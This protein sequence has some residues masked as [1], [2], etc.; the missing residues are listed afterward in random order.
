MTADPRPTGQDG[1]DENRRDRLSELEKDFLFA[2]LLRLPSLFV[3]A[4]E[5]VTPRQ[6]GFG[7]KDSHYACLWQAALNVAQRHGGTMP[8]HPAAARR[9]LD[10]EVR[11][12][13]DND[14]ESFLSPTRDGLLGGGRH[15]AGIIAFIYVLL[16][17]ELCEKTGRDYFRRFLEER[18]VYDDM[19][20]YVASWGHDV[21]HSL[22]PYLQKVQQR[23]A[24]IS[25]LEA[26]ATFA[27]FPERRAFKPL[28]LF[29]TGVP[30]MDRLMNGG[31]AGGEAYTLM[32]PTK[33]GKTTLALQMAVQT[34]LQFQR[35][36]ADG[37]GPLLHVFYFSYEEPVEPRLLHRLWAHLAQIDYDVLDNGLEFTSQE[38]KDYRPYEH[39]RWGAQLSRGLPVPG[40][41]ERFAKACE[42][43]GNRNFW[44][45]DFSGAVPGQGAGGVPEALAVL[46][47][48]RD[49]GKHVGMIVIDYTGLAVQRMLVSGRFSRGFKQSDEFALIQSFPYEVVCQIA[50]PFNCACWVLHQLHGS[51][52]LK[53]PTAPMHHARA[54][55]SRNF[56]DNAAFAFE[57]GNLDPNTSCVWLHRT[58]A[59]RAAPV[60]EP[61]LVRLDGAVRTMVDASEEYAVNPHTK[62]IVRRDELS[63]VGLLGGAS[64]GMEREQALVDRFR[65]NQAR[66]SIFDGMN[67]DK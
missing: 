49:A 57:L 65:S 43:L 56:A 11:R 47:R 50:G 8:E 17:E 30:F 28:R 25:G 31:Q 1:R 19:R 59:R 10:I 7:T 58:A 36:A 6:I 12:I 5:L 37:K 29:S 54:R 51:E 39:E 67:A 22:E 48:A 23:R 2:N 15:G 40:E 13:L 20:Q 26:D 46:L 60:T 4:R 38:K 64:L 44:S 14:P 24:A 9:Q 33:G 55:G 45:V 21:P 32:G 62:K 41:K 18:L 63:R 3:A 27:P 16:P 35:D 66:K 52:S 42:L 53:D 61:T 34:A